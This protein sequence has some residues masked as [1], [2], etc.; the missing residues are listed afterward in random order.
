MHGKPYA[1]YADEVHCVNLRQS[2]NEK[3]WKMIVLGAADP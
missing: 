3:K 2:K 1:L